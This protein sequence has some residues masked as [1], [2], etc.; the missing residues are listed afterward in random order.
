MTLTITEK[1][2]GSRDLSIVLGKSYSV[3]VTS[4]SESTPGLVAAKSKEQNQLL[5][6]MGCKT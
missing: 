1:A 6:R 5:L 4:A 3:A 2:S